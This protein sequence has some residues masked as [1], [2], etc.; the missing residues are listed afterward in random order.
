ML[1]RVLTSHEEVMVDVTQKLSVAE[2]F[3]FATI[4]LR[5]EI[6]EEEDEVADP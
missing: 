2:M 4:Q 3:F 6:C 1:M 5:S